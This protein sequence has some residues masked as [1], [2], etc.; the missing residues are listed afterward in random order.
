MNTDN[1]I[2]NPP[3]Q[4]DSTNEWSA[5]RIA[6]VIL[7]VALCSALVWNAYH[8]ED[9]YISDLK[10][11]VLKS[12]KFEPQKDTSVEGNPLSIHKTYY[13]ARGLGVHADSEIHIRSIPNAYRFFMADIGVD[14]ETPENSPASVVFEVE[15]DGTVLYQSPVMRRGMAPRLVR[16]CLDGRTSITL[17][18][19]DAGDGSEGDHADWAMARF[20]SR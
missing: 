10:Y 3:E 7:L 4:N 16:V 14:N 19:T 2:N 20:T 17:R 9:I 11:E 8:P 5:S 18:V 1:T 13:P 12:T 6:A 15:S